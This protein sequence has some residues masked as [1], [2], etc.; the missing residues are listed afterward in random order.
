MTQHHFFDFCD[1]RRL[2][3]FSIFQIFAH[4]TE[5]P[6]I[7][8]GGSSGTSATTAGSTVKAANTADS[9]NVFGNILAFL[10]AWMILLAAWIR[11]KTTK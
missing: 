7:S 2:N 11:R 10:G 9:A 6:W 1:R 8:A 4:L 3:D 5:N